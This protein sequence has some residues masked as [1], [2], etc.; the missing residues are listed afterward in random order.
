MNAWYATAK[1]LETFTCAAVAA[2][3]FNGFSAANKIVSAA[4][5]Y[6]FTVDL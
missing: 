2:N 4:V 5:W 1:D 6:C 3:A